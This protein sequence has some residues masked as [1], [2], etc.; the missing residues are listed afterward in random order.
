GAFS[1]MSLLVVSNVQHSAHEGP[2]TVTSGR[3]PRISVNAAIRQAMR[4][5]FAFRTLRHDHS[6]LRLLRL[7]QRQN[8]GTE[9]FASIR[10]SQTASGDGAK[11]EV[12]AR[13]LW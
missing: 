12:H 4:K 8:F 11:P 3:D 6:I 2:I 10:P 1:S 5:E 13:N 9:I 7:Y